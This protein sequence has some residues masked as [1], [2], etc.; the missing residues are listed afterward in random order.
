ML[1]EFRERLGGRNKFLGRAK[2]RE[3]AGGTLC[4][5]GELV[6][7]GWAGRQYSSWWVEIG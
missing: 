2:L 1:T 6:G 7:G 5:Q 3:W 4:R